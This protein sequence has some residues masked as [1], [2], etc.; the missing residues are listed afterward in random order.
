MTAFMRSNVLKREEKGMGTVS[1][2]RLLAGGAAAV[3]IFIF[4]SRLLGWLFGCASSI[5]L[6]AGVI[7]FTQPVGGFPLAMY[8]A[9]LVGGWAVLLVA[10]N[11]GSRRSRLMQRVLRIDPADALLDA[12]QIYHSDQEDRDHSFSLAGEREWSLASQL[13]EDGLAFHG[14]LGGLED[15]AGDGLA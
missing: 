13:Q 14:D 6:L 4:A 15:G 8:L 3:L 7:A 5:A 12:S 11:P 10:R 9:D 2:R 1:F